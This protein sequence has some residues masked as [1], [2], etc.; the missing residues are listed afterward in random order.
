M[1]GA[2]GFI[3]SRIVGG[4]LSRHRV[5]V[6]CGRSLDLLRRRFATCELIAATWHTTTPIAGTSASPRTE[7]G[8]GG[9]FCT[10]GVSLGQ[11]P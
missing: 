3:G 1:V 2:G 7:A 6:C 11:T 8:T 10:A 9:Q 4:V 5:V